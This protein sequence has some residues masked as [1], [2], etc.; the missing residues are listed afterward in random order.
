MAKRKPPKQ[1]TPAEEKLLGTMSDADAAQRIGRTVTAVR[2]RRNS[3]GIEAFWT[4]QEL[5]QLGTAPDNDVAAS[6]KRSR[7]SVQRKRTEMDV[8]AF[9]AQGRPKGSKNAE[10]EHAIVRPPQCPSCRSTDRE[11]YRERPRVIRYS[12]VL[13]GAPP[14]EYTHVI[15]RRTRCR[16]CGQ[17]RVD[18]WYEN[19][20]AGCEPAAATIS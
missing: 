6:L 2:K 7:I 8:P 16:N 15:K 18:T 4:S 11:P 14:H 10:Y 5:D 1:W 13:P 3:K 19:V 17:A 12:G 20:P 9:G